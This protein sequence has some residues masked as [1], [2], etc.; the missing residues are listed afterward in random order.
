MGTITNGAQDYVYLEKDTN[1]DVQTWSK[2]YLGA[3]AAYSFAM[4]KDQ[5]SIYYI[6]ND[7]GTHLYFHSANTTNGALIFAYEDSTLSY[8][9]RSDY[10]RV[11]ISDN[12]NIYLSIEDS[13]NNGYIWVYS[14]GCK[15]DY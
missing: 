11:V 4:D 8:K 15:F 3:P 7:S 6:L 13:S 1:S 10:C 9:W 5:S 2:F 12:N 14:T